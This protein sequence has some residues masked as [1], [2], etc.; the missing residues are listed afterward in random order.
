[1]VFVPPECLF[2]P[3][4]AVDEFLGRDVVPLVPVDDEP[5]SLVVPF[6]VVPLPEPE[7]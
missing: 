7:C 5:D 4:V 1:V 6:P 2:A 3:E